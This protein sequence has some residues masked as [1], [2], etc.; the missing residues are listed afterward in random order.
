[1]NKQTKQTASVKLWLAKI[2]LTGALVLTTLAPFVVNAAAEQTQT[3]QD[4]ATPTPTPEP[5][6]PPVEYNVSWNT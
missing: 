3:V 6:R 4:T 1:M 5:I 2:V